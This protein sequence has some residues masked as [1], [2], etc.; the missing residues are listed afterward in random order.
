MELAAF[1]VGMRAAADALMRGED[2]H[3]ETD[4]DRDLPISPHIGEDPHPELDGCRG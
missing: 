4:G 3:P 2:P 1:R